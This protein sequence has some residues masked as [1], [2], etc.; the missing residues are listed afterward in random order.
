MRNTGRVN[1]AVNKILEGAPVSQVLSENID[2]DWKRDSKRRSAKVN[3]DIAMEMLRSLSPGKKVQLDKML[4][5]NAALTSSYSCSAG[6][7]RVY[8]QGWYLTLNATR[9]AFSV[10]MYDNDGEFV[11]A[12]KPV[13]SKLDFLYEQDL[14]F[15]MM[16]ESDWGNLVK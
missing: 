10:W 14:T 11:E 13:E 8:K 3:Y 7:L 16:G 1:N 15:N 2:D 6:T 12:R 5:R 9:S 4:S